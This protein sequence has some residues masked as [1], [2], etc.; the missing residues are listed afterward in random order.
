[1]KAAHISN[2]KGLPFNFSLQC[3]DAA[4]WVIGSRVQ[5]T[6]FLKKSNPPGFCVLG[7]TGFIG[8]FL[9][10][11][12]FGKLVGCFSSSAKLLFRFA[13]TLDYLKICKIITYWS[14]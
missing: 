4:G 7:F 9:F 1:V 3:F 5:K 8:F 2:S 6:H 10:E 12:A 13:S 14:L 11:Q